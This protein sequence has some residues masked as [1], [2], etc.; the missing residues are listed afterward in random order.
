MPLGTHQ[1]YCDE[2]HRDAFIKARVKAA[3]RQ[4]KMRD[5]IAEMKRAVYEEA[6]APAGNS[7]MMGAN[8]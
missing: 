2:H 7:Q 8:F 1:Q 5:E 4:K 3:M 6:A